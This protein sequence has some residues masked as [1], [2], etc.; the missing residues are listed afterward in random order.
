MIVSSDCDEL[1]P[2][3]VRIQIQSGQAPLRMGDLA[4]ALGDGSVAD[5]LAETILG[6]GFDAVLWECPALHD[7]VLD[8]PFECVVR[9]APALA[10][11]RCD[12]DPFR[13]YLDGEDSIATFDNLGRDA[14]LIAP[15]LRGRD[16]THLVSFLHRA[17]TRLQHRF[18]AVVSTE[19]Q[20]RVGP[21]PVWL[22]TS[23]LGVGWLHVRI[24]R[25]P[26][27]Y[28]HAAYTAVS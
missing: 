20:R 10:R 8:Q 14:R 21:E 16:Y 12:P 22:N 15:P 28:S 1:A 18:W 5:L 3:L 7:R 11:M 23:G 4:E 24:D 6:T 27:Y 13:A 25:Y 9:D 26:K 2:G 19:L 17:P